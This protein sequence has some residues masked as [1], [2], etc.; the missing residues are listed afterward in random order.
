MKPK[1]SREQKKKNNTVPRWRK[2]NNKQMDD[3]QWHELSYFIEWQTPQWSWFQYLFLSLSL[4][5]ITFGD[6]LSC[7]IIFKYLMNSIKSFN[8]SQK[9]YTTNLSSTLIFSFPLTFPKIHVYQKLF[10]VIHSVVFFFFFVFSSFYLSILVF[11]VSFVKLYSP[12][13]TQTS[14]DTHISYTRKIT[15]R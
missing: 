2:H 11:R 10:G 14:I 12:N 5:P 6:L 7:V 8:S 4:F 3:L 1:R 9:R 13:K 15:F